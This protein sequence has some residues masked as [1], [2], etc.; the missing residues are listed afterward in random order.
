[1]RFFMNPNGSIIEKILEIG[2]A[3]C[4]FLMG[5]LSIAFVIFCICCFFHYFDS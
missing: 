5:I 3:S 2:I 4:A 1:M